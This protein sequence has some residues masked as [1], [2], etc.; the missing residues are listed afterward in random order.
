VVIDADAAQIPVGVDGEAL[1]LTPGALC[2]AAGRAAGGFCAAPKVPDLKP[3]W[4]ARLAA[5][6]AGQQRRWITALV[7]RGDAAGGD[8]HGGS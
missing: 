5:G 3:S 8:A 1:V 7:G 2:R 4:M 6:P